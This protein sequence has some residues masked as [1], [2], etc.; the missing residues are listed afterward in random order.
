MMAW[1]ASVV[2]VMWQATCGVVMTPSGRRKAGRIV[3]LLH[4]ERIAVDCAAVEARRRASLEPA[5]AK[6]EAIERS[7]RPS[8]GASLMRPA[9]IFFSPIWMRPLKKVPVVSTT[10]PARISRPSAV[11][12][13]AALPVLDD[14]VLDRGFDHVEVRRGAD[15]RLHGLAV[16]LAVGLGAGT[17]HRR[18]FAAVQHAELDAGQVGDLAHQ[19]VEGVDLAD[20]MTLAEPANGRIAGH[21]AD[22]GEAVGDQRRARAHARRSGSSLAAGMAAADHDNVEG[23]GIPRFVHGACT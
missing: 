13:P 18:A 12:M 4:L 22:G 21:L 3:A 8:A 15:R 9:G 16:E 7:E 10:A 5:H 6:A 20:Q 1:V 2:W 23:V 19:A 17:L 14:Q 11:T